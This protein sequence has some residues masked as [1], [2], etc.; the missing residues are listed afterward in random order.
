[1]SFTIMSGGNKVVSNLSFLLFVEKYKIPSCVKHFK[2][3][4]INFDQSRFMSKSFCVF[5][6]FEKVGGSKIIM[7]NF[8]LFFSKNDF[9]SLFIKVYFSFEEDNPFSS[10]FF[11]AQDK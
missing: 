1:M 11:L 2:Q 5:L 3:S 10:K 6:E 4:S 9:T 8:S 7:S